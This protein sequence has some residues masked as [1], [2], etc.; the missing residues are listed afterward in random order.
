[1]LHHLHGRKY[2]YYQTCVLGDAAGIAAVT[3]LLS[4]DSAYGLKDINGVREVLKKYYAI[5]DTDELN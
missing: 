2:E 3:C 4:G 1:M 5:L